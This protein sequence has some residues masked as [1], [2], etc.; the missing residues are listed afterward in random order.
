MQIECILKRRGGTRAS[1]E[2]V[3]YH[4][5][6]IDPSDE[7]TPHV[8]EVTNKKHAQRFL[9]IPEGYR[10]Y[11]A[12]ANE[13]AEAPVPQDQ[14]PDNGQAQGQPEPTTEIVGDDEQPPADD[15]LDAGGTEEAEA[16]RTG[17][18][19][20]VNGGP[21]S[22][23]VKANIRA[24]ESVSAIRDWAGKANIDVEIPGNMKPANAAER[25]IEAMEAQ[26][27]G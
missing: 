8:A 3:D 14:E 10:I 27:A 20:A 26:S 17:E 4:F 24:M 16:A 19:P 23:A 12:G 7:K 5:Q 9:A 21:V 25:V 22:D 15:A 11:Q 18:G 13:Q 2:G 6:P 1:I